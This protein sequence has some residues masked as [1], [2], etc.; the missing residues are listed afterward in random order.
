MVNIENPPPRGCGT[1]TNGERACLFSDAPSRRFPNC[2]PRRLGIFQNIYIFFSL[3]VFF[4]TATRLLGQIVIKLFG[5]NY[6][7]NGMLYI[8]FGLGAL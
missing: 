6:L 3:C 8:S 4:Q 1:L 7:I 5:P 2:A